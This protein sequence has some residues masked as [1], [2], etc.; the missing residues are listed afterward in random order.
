MIKKIA[1]MHTIDGPAGVSKT[2]A[3][4]R[5]RIADAAPMIEAITA[6]ASGVLARVRAAAAG[7]ISI[8]TMS[9]TPTTLTAT[10]TVSPN[11]SVMRSFS[12]FGLNPLA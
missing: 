10:A 9:K 11:D 6:I 4:L 3:A 8:A 7:M 5:P 2:K 12:L 1:A